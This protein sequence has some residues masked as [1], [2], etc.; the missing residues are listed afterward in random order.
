MNSVQLQNLHDNETQTCNEQIDELTF[1]TCA[2]LEEILKELKQ[3]GCLENELLRIN[4]PDANPV[5][6]EKNESDAHCC[7]EVELLKEQ[8]NDLRKQLREEAN[9]EE[10]CNDAIERLKE[11]EIQNAQLLHDNKNLS[12]KLTESENKLADMLKKLEKL[13]AEINRNGQEATVIGRGLEENI[14]LV[15]NI[16]DFQLKNQQLANAVSAINSRD[17]EKIIDDLRRQLE[18]EMSKLKKCQQDNAY[19]TKERTQLEGNLKEVKEL[20][21]KLIAENNSLKNNRTAR[22]K[23]TDESK[24]KEKPA[25]EDGFATSSTTKETARKKPKV[26]QQNKPAE[27]TIQLV[28]EKPKLKRRPIVADQQKVADVTDSDGF[29]TSSTT[30]EPIQLILT[31]PKPK[32]ATEHKLSPSKVTSARQFGHDPSKDLALSDF[33]RKRSDTFKFSLQEGQSFEK[34]FRKILEEFILECSSYFCRLFN[35]RS[36]LYIICHKLC[37]HGIDALNFQELAYIHKKIYNQADKLL[38]GCMLDMILTEHRAQVESILTSVVMPRLME[39]QKLSFKTSG[40]NVGNDDHKCC[41]CKNELCCSKS[42]EMLKEKGKYYRS[43][44]AAFI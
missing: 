31:R 41:R 35:A 38:P 25:T 11:L 3:R 26:A 13:D 14:A 17:D 43:Y 8:I 34:E 18:E 23:K 10:I 2:T 44:I 21:N 36:K 7:Q 40:G 32:P 6:V 9:C 39:R 42:D 1:Y 12:L 27:E 4:E 15:K 29:V 5:Y 16:S 19:L 24:Y 30:K 22:E 37:H 20:N 28:L 33:V